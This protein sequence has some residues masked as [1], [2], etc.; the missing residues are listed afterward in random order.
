M[1]YSQAKGRRPFERASKIAHAEILTLDLATGKT[2]KVTDVDHSIGIILGAA[3][4]R[5]R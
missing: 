5:S 3:P 2:N 1:G 4:V